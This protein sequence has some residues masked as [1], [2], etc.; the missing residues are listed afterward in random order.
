MTRAK[1]SART[2]GSSPVT[3]RSQ[4]VKLNATKVATTQQQPAVDTPGMQEVTHVSDDIIDALPEVTDQE[5]QE[6]EPVEEEPE[7]PEQPESEEPKE[8]EQPESEEPVEEE[9]VEEEPKEPEQPVEKPTEPMEQPVKKPTEPMEQPVVDERLALYENNIQQLVTTL[10]N[11]ATNGT[12][13]DTL[14]IITEMTVPHTVCGID[15]FDR[16]CAGYRATGPKIDISP[17]IIEKQKVLSTFAALPDRQRVEAWAKAAAKTDILSILD[18]VDESAL[19]GVL[20]VL[21]Q[22]ADGWFREQMGM[23]GS[24]T[25]LSKLSADDLLDIQYAMTRLQQKKKKQGKPARKRMVKR[26]VRENGNDGESKIPK[27][28]E[29]NEGLLLPDTHSDAFFENECQNLESLLRVLERRLT[30]PGVRKSG[31]CQVESTKKNIAETDD[32]GKVISPVPALEWYGSLLSLPSPHIPD[33]SSMDEQEQEDFL[34]HYL[35]SVK[36]VHDKAGP[37]AFGQP[38]STQKYPQYIGIEGKLHSFLQQVLSSHDM[39]EVGP[40]VG[41]QQY[42][43]ACLLLYVEDLELM[44]VLPPSYMCQGFVGRLRSHNR[45]ITWCS[46]YREGLTRLPTRPCNRLFGEER[47]GLLCF[48]EPNSHRKNETTTSSSDGD[49]DGR[50]DGGEDGGEPSKKKPKCDTAF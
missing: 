15:V 10:V 5:M 12:W 26:T 38:A 19:S 18:S 3:R 7:E 8:P 37:R 50:G 14:S 23:Q 13:E 4:L 49:E 9:P 11:A 46:R 21:V 29:G 42:S 35:R 48:Q 39:Y 2:V 34:G 41:K 40:G 25:D 30:R 6:F 43:K 1:R 27:T 33:W 28:K 44:L 31:W 32:D 24:H 20:P 36:L 47:A 45:V 16:F 17:E 22:S